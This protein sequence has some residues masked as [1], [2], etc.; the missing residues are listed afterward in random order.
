MAE[1]TYDV[2]KKILVDQGFVGQ[3]QFDDALNHAKKTKERLVNVLLDRDL[4]SLRNWGQL[5]AKYIGYQYVFLQ[6]ENIEPQVLHVIPELVARNNKIIAFAQGDGF[7]KVAMNNPNDLEM[8]NVLEKKSGVVVKVY[9]ATAED[10]DATISRYKK[11]IVEDFQELIKASQAM[12]GKAVS[13]TTVIT[14]VE[15]LLS[16][17]HQNNASDVHIEPH[18]QKIVI[19]LRIDGILHFLLDIPIELHDMIVGRIKVMAKLKT[20]EH[21][22]AQDG[23][24]RHSIDTEKVD[25]RVSVIPVVDGERVVMRLLSNRNRQFTLSHLG[26]DPA[27]LETIQ[28]SARRSYGMILAT[29]PTGSG[30]TTTLYSIIKMVN[31]LKVNI[32]TIEDP[33]EYDMEGVN[34][35]QVNPKANL[36]FANG[37]K[38]LLRQD[39]D[40]IMLGEIRDD[41]TASLAVNAALTGHLLLSTLHSNDAATSFPR[42]QE[43]KISPYLITSAIII[44]I[45]Q[46]LVRNLC[47][48][49]RYGI[50]L[51]EAEIEQFK[52]N[53]ELTRWVEQHLRPGARFYRA[54]GCKVC[55]NFGFTGRSGIFEVM[56]MND[57]L[58]KAVLEGADAGQIRQVAINQGMRTLVEDG[59]NKVLAGITTPEEI[60][61]A[62]SV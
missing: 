40:I 17:A 6:E 23:K 55:N 14:M 46:R 28:R 3:Q 26:L 45:A 51:S 12:I 10:I 43:M 27:D 42:L 24:I 21:R 59:M 25:I 48:K 47:V 8:V 22:T 58:R 20:D 15:K 18:E 36:T 50:D 41:E 37:L 30:K 35:I 9:Y 53:S 19:R 54:K 4:I 56:M 34:Q 13:D 38:S 33:V 29:G 44:V 7:I 52:K 16:Y 60:I 2:V 39:P 32:A 62:I 31:S 49:C 11:S 1:V 5:Y 57:A 61:R